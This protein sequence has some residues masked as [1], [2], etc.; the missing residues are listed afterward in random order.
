[1]GLPVSKSGLRSLMIQLQPPVP[2]SRSWEPTDGVAS[3][4]EVTRASENAA[5]A[6]GASTRRLGDATPS[7]PSE[8]G[9]VLIVPWCSTVTSSDSPA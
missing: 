7:L 9:K 1:M 5:G 6:Q 2:D 8:T 3:S 4:S